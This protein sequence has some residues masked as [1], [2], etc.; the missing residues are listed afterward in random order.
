MNSIKKNIPNIVTL[1]NL[2]SGCIAVVLASRHSFSLAFLFILVG[3]FFDFFDGVLARLLKTTSEIGKQLDS[4]ADLASFGIAPALICFF[5]FEQII[6][7]L[8][9]ILLLL[10]S[11]VAYRLSK[12]N[13]MESNQK[14]FVGMPSPIV[15]I[16][17][18]SLP[19]TI[20][21]YKFLASSNVSL[22]IIVA[23]FI[24]LLSSFVMLSDFTY[25]KLKL[26]NKYHLIVLIASIILLYY[27][28]T[29][30]L[31]PIY[32]FY[33]LSPMIVKQKSF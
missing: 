28:S 6:H 14:F 20:Q 19:Y 18:A 29:I 23:L 16:L 11:I 33:L 31:L 10:P 2:V 25:I 9:Y 24:L 30:I 1:M 17:F 7:E 21:E 22:F 13:L 8:A 3:A 27:F 32:I 26:S 5:F 12:F 15:G 4:F